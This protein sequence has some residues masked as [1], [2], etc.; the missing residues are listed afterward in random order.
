MATL[1]AMN[2]VYQVNFYCT[3]G[4]QTA[5]PRMHYRID[6]IVGAPTDD[7]L[8]LTMSATFQAA[9]KALMTS[10]ATYRGV[11]VQ[12]LFPLP[13]T[14]QVF[15]T[16][17]NG[18]GDNITTPL[19]KQVSGLVSKKTAFASRNMRGRFYMPF[20]SEGNNDPTNARPNAGY[21][22]QLQTLAGLLVNKVQDAVGPDTWD[23]TPI[24]YS[25]SGA[26]I[27]GS[28]LTQCVARTYWA[29]QRRRGDFGAT[30]T[31]PL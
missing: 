13:K 30:N 24:I 17:G 21:I 28:D 27:N 29:T 23:A 16:Q 6:N 10:E 12:R 25:G 1:L 31:S 5:I 26:H 3:F 11:G 4:V 14:A 7:M 20:P 18:P 22:T 15:S 19:P 9:I 2:D 8:A